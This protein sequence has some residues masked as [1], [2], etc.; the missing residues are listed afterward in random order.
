MTRKLF[1]VARGGAVPRP[2]AAAAWSTRRSGA[3]AGLSRDTTP[4][5]APRIRPVHRSARVPERRSTSLP[6][7]SLPLARQDLTAPAPGCS[8][9]LI[10]PARR[11]A[12]DGGSAPMG[13]TAGGLVVCRA[14][15]AAV[16]VT[17]SR[18]ATGRPHSIPG[19]A[20]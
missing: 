9:S 20:G 3:T 15:D 2:T 6:R 16:L 13:R 1:I 14:P 10:E 5:L 11:N 8:Q 18:P 12:A 4:D 7:P 19:R 17:A